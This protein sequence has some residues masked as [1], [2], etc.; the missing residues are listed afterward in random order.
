MGNHPRIES[1]TEASFI[2]TRSRN[3]E[4]WFIN[5]P[6]LEHAS[7]GYVAKFAQ[8]YGVVLYAFAIE[9][10]HNHT[11]ALFPNANRA[12]FMRDLNSCIARAVARYT[13]E[14]P[15]GSFW[16]RR[17]SS[18][19]LPSPED[20][21]EQFFYTVLQ[22][23]QDGLAPT[24]SQSPGYNCFHDAV[25]GIKRKF[26]VINWAK[27]NA[28]KRKNPKVRIK[29][30]TEIV[31][32]EYARLPGY[33][34][35]SQKEYAKLMHQELEKRRVRIVEERIKS[36]KGFANPE[37]LKLTPRGYRPKHTKTSDIN[38]HRPRVL[39]RCPELREQTLTIYFSIIAEHKEA[40]RRYRAG[41]F[42]VEFPP[43]TYRPYVRNLA[44]P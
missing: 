39:S 16:G 5:N 37:S 28:A 35:L 40:S 30:Y 18:E 27:Y 14:Y 9:G 22:P 31:T 23:V 6:E 10:S 26:T 17:Y 41:E 11:P 29:D 19:I 4:L 20:I 13:P 3:S 34:H 44:S 32:L 8:R 2:T 21:K 25:W 24:I 38:S 36:G 33:E 7:L 12:D 15:G 42:D 1:R 43:G